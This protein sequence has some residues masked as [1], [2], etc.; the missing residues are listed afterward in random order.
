MA[1]CGA[2]PNGPRRPPRHNRDE[3]WLKDLEVT[4]EMP[5]V[6]LHGWLRRGWLRNRRLNGRRVIIANRTEIRRLQRLRERCVWYG[7]WHTIHRPDENGS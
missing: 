6:T 7:R 1:R 2:S 3:W 4:L 5:V